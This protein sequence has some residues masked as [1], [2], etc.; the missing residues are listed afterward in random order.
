MCIY[1]YIYIY[2]CVCDIYIYMCVCVCVRIMVFNILR[3][4][5]YSA[6]FSVCLFDASEHLWSAFTPAG[7]KISSQGQGESYTFA[8][9]A[10]W[11]P[12]RTWDLQY[13]WYANSWKPTRSS[14][15]QSN[16]E[17]VCRRCD[18]ARR[19]GQVH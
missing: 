14:R 11:Q 15:A 17:G 19:H 12:V 2:V 1:I 4:N 10:A 3:N 8:N 7:E 9:T 5:I 6:G 13:H 18:D 16:E